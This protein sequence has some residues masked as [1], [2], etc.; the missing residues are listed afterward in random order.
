MR[1][2]ILTGLALASLSIMPARASTDAPDDSHLWLE[3]VTGDKQL[4]WVRE[5]NAVSTRELE[6]SPGFEQTRAALL[7]I[8][9]SREKIPYVAKHGAHYYNF[10]QDE[11]HVRGVWRRTTFAEYRK[12]APAWE[13]VIDLDALAAAENENWVWHGADILY[14]DRDRALVKFSRGGADADVVREFDLKTKTFVAPGAGG[15]A[16]PEAKSRVAWRDRDTLY[17]GTDF[18]AG[19]LTDSG[20]PRIVKEWKRGT[21]LA[22]AATIF[23]ADKTDMSVSAFRIHDHGA[24]Y[25]MILRRP[26][27]FTN[28]VLLRN[29]AGAW[30]RLDKPDDVSV[31]VHRGQI[32]LV[33]RKDWT[34][35]GR[36]HAAG[37]LLA[38]DLK[39]YL[40][41]ARDFTVLFEPGPRKSLAGTA[42]TKNHLV[43]NEL[44]NVRNK[45]FA[46]TLDAATGKWTRQPVPA[47]DFGV[48]SI[49]G[50]DEDESDD[51]FIQT[52][53]FLTP[54]SL[55]LG[56]IGKSKRETLKRLPAFFDAGGMKV[57][58]Y[59]ATSADGMRVPYF[60]LAPKSF[61]ADG[62]A[63]ALLYGYGGFQISMLPDYKAHF[64]RAWVAR[65]GVYVLANLRGGGEFGP[66]WHQAALREKRQRAYDDFAAIAEDLIARKITSPARLGI[67]GGSNGGLLVGAA[68]TQRPDL[69]R[70]VVCQVPLLDMRRYNKLLAGASWMAEYGNPDVPEDWAFIKKYS[71]YQNVKPGVKYPR[72]LF[73]TS[74]RD[75]RVHPAH[76]RKMVA[77]ME[78]QGHDVLYYE[79]IEG[80][81]GGAANAGQRARM[82]ALS[83]TFL[84]KELGL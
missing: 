25:D 11:N 26:A 19:S 18:G 7:A 37:A 56:T 65:G 22:S 28:E 9:N 71:P 69:Y 13:T 74:T 41:G 14:P 20:Y 66:A 30:V 83:F 45:L 52:Q 82:W 36:T 68:F 42:D 4:A 70:A 58:Q 76:A 77:L 44:E 38:A 40:A 61:R 43:V 80:G 15:F 72:V 79:N 84:A 23:E 60:V 47:P 57:F 1:K 48:T 49:S 51:V 54:P 8:Y 12:T 31:G 17:V 75:D 67:M 39:R 10:W 32:L 78:A 24:H 21:P 53:D 81:H 16:L 6:S 46:W 35:G 62:T 3:D 64:G 59:E 29:P 27:F 34:V 33:L 2:L 73:T 55:V 5:R 50:I 63:P